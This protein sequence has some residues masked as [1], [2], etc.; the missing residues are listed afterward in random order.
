MKSGY[1]Y[2]ISRTF[3]IDDNLLQVNIYDNQDDSTSLRLVYEVLAGKINS[4]NT[5]ELY[6][7]T[8]CFRVYDAVYEWHNKR[9]KEKI[10]KAMDSLDVI[11]SYA[12]DVIAEARK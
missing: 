1:R 8:N 5:L 12:V 9:F 3:T 6:Q 11:E 4:V 7:G 2:V 10:D